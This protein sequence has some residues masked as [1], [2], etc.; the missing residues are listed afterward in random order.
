MNRTHFSLPM[1]IKGF[2]ILMNRTR[3]SILTALLVILSACG[4]HG[5]HESH[6]G[7]DHETHDHEHQHSPAHVH[8]EDHVH[9]EDAEDHGHDGEGHNPDEIIL[10]PSQAEAA[11]V[12]CSEV[13]PGEFNSVVKTGGRILTASGDE[14]TV[15][16]PAAGIVSMKKG[17][18]EGMAVGKG[19]PVM[20]VSSAK[21]PEG[22]TSRR[23][24][25]AYAQ[26]KADFERA[27]K[28]KADNLITDKDYEA[29]KAEYERTKLAYEAI[30]G[31][32]S[33]SGVTVTAPTGGYIKE[34]L[35]RDGDF[36]EV[37]Q[38][39]M[40]LTQNRR[41]F[42][43]AD[44]SE[45][46]YGCI[47]SIASAKFKPS[48]SETVYNLRD[49]D[50]RLVAS[51]QT[52]SASGSFIPVTFEFNNAGGVIPGSFV[53]VY[54][55]GGRRD[56]VISVPVGALTEEQGVKFVYIK[57]DEEGY[58][59]R[60]VKTGQTDGERIEILEGLAP[61]E[62]VVTEGAIHVKLASAKAAIPAH[63]HNH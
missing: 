28:L 9:G 24:E 39:V 5:S 50:G 7:H 11:G 45:R 52:A 23:N 43:R 10:T 54:L 35:V 3:F 37:G 62:N 14:S 42:L 46:D 34:C 13:T 41:L 21:L 20:T 15:V 59:K 17:Y 51:A 58:M 56:N 57:V 49:L 2:P 30:G 61:G 32:V 6:D 27:E 22:E 36:V 47:G 33:T 55:V 44:V 29:A 63:N 18:T 60:E 12:R 16:A 40:R 53:E 1:N 48:Y 19:A 26:A 38:P 8:D 4:S 31:K 25:I